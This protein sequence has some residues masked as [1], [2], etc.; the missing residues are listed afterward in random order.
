MKKKGILTFL[1][2]ILLLIP[3]IVFAQEEVTTK[4][5]GVITAKP[6]EVVAYDIKVTTPDDIKAKE[7]SAKLDYDK[8]ILE[9]KGV[10]AKSL[11]SG[12]SDANSINYSYK[13]GITGTSTIAT[14][15]FKVKDNVSKQTTIVSLKD[16]KITTLDGDDNKSILTVQ[17]NSSHKVSLAIKS[18]DNTLKDLKVDGI[19]IEGFKSDV[20]EYELEVT[21]DIDKIE[22]KA[23]ANNANATL[24]EGFGNRVES[25]EYGENEFLIKVKAES[26]EIQVYKLVV[27]RED[28][29]NTNNNLKEIIINSG[30]IK[31]ELSKN[32]VNYTIKTYKLKKLEVD[33]IAIDDKAT[34]KIE[35]PEEIIVGENI[36]IITVTS[37]NGEDKVYTLTFNNTDETI[38]TKL[39]TLYIKGYNIDFDK[40]TMVYK[41]VF[42]KKYKKGLDISA[43]TVFGDDLVEYKIY[44]NEKEIDE[45]TK[46]ELKPGDKYEIKVMPIGLEE[47]ENS[48]STVYTISIVKDK[49][50]SFFLV[51]EIFIAL[52]LTVLIIIQVVKRNK[53]RKEKKEEIA[54]KETKKKP[55]SNKVEKEV[56][57]TKVMSKEELDKINNNNKE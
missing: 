47:G 27:I 52:I 26:G 35:T 25:L 3:T 42:N 34:V 31:L 32:K 16:I 48:D 43:V 20:F 8:D 21:S 28:D 51:L 18:T 56:E 36:V 4:F 6:G 23:F 39:K 54:K 46:I 19:T 33:A 40:N 1:I 15:T 11:W 53:I 37:E 9:L 49:R 10:S 22:L 7:Y 45:D 14:V 29:R 57:K 30:K 17:E 44:Y 5:E 24:V 38:D 12:T 55:S 13:D 41:I 2:G 50:I